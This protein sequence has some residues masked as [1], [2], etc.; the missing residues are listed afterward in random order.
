MPGRLF[1]LFR[2]SPPE[3]TPSSD[4]FTQ[5]IKTYAKGLSS[6]QG[7]DLDSAPID[8]QAG[9]VLFDIALRAL[10]A[11]GHIAQ[12]ND[13]DEQIALL[14]FAMLGSSPLVA[15]LRKEGH[16]IEHDTVF[17]VAA[18]AFTANLDSEAREHTLEL[19]AGLLKRF[20]EQA[21]KKDNY[22]AWL[23]M[24]RQMIWGLVVSDKPEL[25]QALAG[26]YIALR[27][28]VEQLSGTA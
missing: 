9:L 19:S 17:G 18:A 12:V 28:A 7:R 25:R 23:D 26:H 2:S 5:A 13:V 3:P 4:E 22:E 15:H 10:N 6:T 27:A 14:M 11:S 1:K 21:Q 24:N 20:I 16:A 8:E